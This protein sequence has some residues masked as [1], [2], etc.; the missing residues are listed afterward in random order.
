MQSKQ[1]SDENI[2]SSS[3]F[4]EDHAPAFARLGG[5]KAWCS[6]PGDK[7]PYIQI[8]LDEEK[9]ITSITT[10]GSLQDLSWARKYEV[11]YFDKGKWVSY[12][13]VKF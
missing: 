6:A 2:T 11:K 12:H 1:I 5:R 10:Q 9:T 7:S 3:K 4:S 8:L 13:Q